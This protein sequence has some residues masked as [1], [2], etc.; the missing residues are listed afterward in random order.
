MKKL[1]SYL[2]YYRTEAILAPLFKMLEAFFE[3][4]VPLVIAAMID[5]GIARGNRGVIFS[6]AA[7]LV[8]LCFVGF[9]ASVTAQ[10]FSAKAAAGFARRVRY[11]L[12]DNIQKLSYTQLDKLGS[13]SLITRMTSDMNQVQQG[14]N[15]TLRLLLRSQFIVFGAMIMAFT[16]DVREALIFAVAIPMLGLTVFLVM[17]YC[18]PGYRRVQAGLDGLLTLVRENLSGVRVIRAFRIEKAEKERFFDRNEELT[19]LQEKV[20]RISAL[21]N[22]ITLLILNI[23]IAILIYTGAVKVFA[24]ELT[25]GE[26]V[27]LYNYM[28]QILIELIKFANL[29]I[30]ITRAIA[31]GR[32]VQ[33]QLETVPDKDGGTLTAEDAGGDIVAF[34]K[35]F[36]RYDQ[37]ADD[38]LEDISFTVRRGEK[39][40]II[41]GTGSGKT[42]LVNLIPGFYKA[43]GGQV[44]VFGKDV[45]ELDMSWL[46][47]RIGIVPQKA[48]LFSGTVRENMLW[49]NENATDEE[50]WE[51][52]EAAMAAPF[53]RTKNKGIDYV[54]EQ[55]GRNLSGG[56]RQRLTIARALVRKPDILILDDSASALDYQ[57]EYGLR[58]ALFSLDYDPTVFIIS[59]RTS[60]I[61]GCDRILVMDDGRIVGNASHDELLSSCDEYREIYES[62]LA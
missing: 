22:P 9:A 56:Q 33:A 15:L 29:I 53:I 31:C 57:T 2:K 26:V 46:R 60:S 38:D 39:I 42:T 52:L 24:G 30:T 55:G 1:L 61:S 37:A 40:G 17:L 32:R 28:S 18:L 11:D 44:R 45:K 36:M 34:D 43:T 58:Q 47:S 14:V 5:E 25:Q 23:A 7:I 10:Y 62:Q 20:G 19:R 48:V 41:G 54:L 13:S 27:A 50:I 4:M 8:L 6:K 49:G 12:F 59:Q 51:A 35:V 3:L 16:I 21:M